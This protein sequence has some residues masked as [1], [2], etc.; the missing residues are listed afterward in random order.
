MHLFSVVLVPIHTHGRRLL[1]LIRRF[2]RLTGLT[3]MVPQKAHR[4]VTLS[5]ND[6]ECRIQ[7]PTTNYY[8]KAYFFWSSRSRK[9]RHGRLIVQTPPNPTKTFM[10]SCR[11]VNTR[12]YPKPFS[13]GVRRFPDS[14][15]FLKACR[16]VPPTV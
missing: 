8:D 11:W 4:H 3:L 14:L 9:V 7:S 5:R 15:G 10:G 1:S 12:I 13:S 6:K 16:V 2:Q